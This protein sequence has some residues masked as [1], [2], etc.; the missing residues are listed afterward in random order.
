M[1]NSAIL[2]YISGIIGILSIII[3]IINRKRIRST[4]C[5][6]EIEASFQVEDIKNNSNKDLTKLEKVEVKE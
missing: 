2:N 6:R 3:G 5:H 1:D 4:C